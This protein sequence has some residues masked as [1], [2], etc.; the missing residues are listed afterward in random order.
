[1]IPL[2]L[3]PFDIKLKKDAE[4]DILVHDFLRRK[5]LKLTPEEWVRQH[6]THYLVEQKH[7]PAGLLANE[8]GININGNIRR[9]DTVLYD[10]QGMRPRVIVEYKA[11]HVCITQEV[12]HQISSYNSVLRADYLIVSNGLQHILCKV[13]FENRKYIFAEQWPKYNELI[14]KN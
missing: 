5:W 4:G 13:D 14:I 7:F 12:F 11:P 2:N 9:C 10:R 1:M 8:V 6:F 3:P